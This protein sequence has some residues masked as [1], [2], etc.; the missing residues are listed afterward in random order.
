MR[1]KRKERR[2]DAPGPR[3]AA[4]AP[5]ALEDP[6][7]RVARILDALGLGAL[8]FVLA[9]R[10]LK[11]G[12]VEDYG[13]DVVFGMALLVSLVCWAGGFVL[14]PDRA[15][16]A[17][18]PLGALGVLLALTAAAVLGACDLF[19]G[20]HDLWNLAL[21]V[22]V[23]FLS[24]RHMRTP[25]GRRVLP[26][27]L[28]AAL[29]V[30]AY[31][32]LFHYVV[33]MPAMRRWYEQN[34]S[35]FLQTVEAG[36]RLATALQQRLITP[37]AQ[38]NYLTPNQ[39]GAA[40]VLTLFLAAAHL[41]RVWA[42]RPGV[43]RRGVPLVVIA[44]ALAAFACA[45]SN[46]ASVA[47]VA[48]LVFVA[49]VR[50]WRRW[51]GR[52]GR[53]GRALAVAAFVLLALGGG[54][55]GGL[56]LARLPALGGAR[57]SLGVRLGYWR[58][59]LDMMALRPLTGIGPG[60]WGDW[61]PLLKAPEYEETQLP[62]NDFL[63]IASESGLPA[64]AAWVGF[65]A[66]VILPGA[67]ARKRAADAPLGGG[68]GA[69]DA[70]EVGEAEGSESPSPSW[71][72]FILILGAAVFSFDHGFVGTFRP[73]KV[74]VEPAWLR[75]AAV[76]YVLLWAIWTL[77]AVAVAGWGGRERR[78]SS[79]R[80]ELTPLLAA[81]LVGFA[82]HGTADFLLAIGGLGTVAFFAAGWL[83]ART[84]TGRAWRPGA[85]V[86]YVIFTGAAVA[87][88]LAG[89][90]VVERVL[91]FQFGRDLEFAL[92]AEA[93]GA[94]SV[95]TGP[96][97]QLGRVIEAL[98]EAHEAIP[99][100]GETLNRLGGYRMHKARLLYAAR[101]G[102]E[103]RRPD[104]AA[105]AAYR[106]GAELNPMKAKYRVSLGNWYL[107]HR[108]AARAAAYYLEAVRRS[109]TRPEGWLQYAAAERDARGLATEAV[110]AAARRA[111]AL[112]P[113][114][115]HER[116]RLNEKQKAL[117]RRLIAECAGPGAEPH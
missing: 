25:A 17:D 74:G 115:Y 10:P 33:Y 112:S 57:A 19:S 40:L 98:E 9:Y 30:V 38:G 41:R 108:E 117:A 77:V 100:D 91:T 66:L 99:F 32:G 50:A 104:G 93:T 11:T 71:L 114:Q 15:L 88:V 34:P 49:L 46:G 22:L 78:A 51:A 72:L 7:A 107:A 97:E 36:G 59:T 68:R 85:P 43:L 18:R 31:F 3:L 56:A 70:G 95:G 60:C 5:A 16:R 94:R 109:P 80:A 86:R 92:R 103:A 37:R 12:I 8:A 101:R 45:R 20:L 4:P 81:A 53:R 96:Y 2:P 63:Q 113:R 24:A 28:L 58:T 75:P 102:E 54:A 84:G 42:V 62:H 69:G 87:S 111:L 73:P 106:R 61:Y 21:Y 29:A 44:L 55:G 90:V 1:G 26:A 52:L 23:F 39:L 35:Y 13:G 116:N 6:R 110:C 82:V 48:A 47:L 64:L 65:L 83:A 105:L 67:G 89:F 14:R 76:P 27:V 79:D